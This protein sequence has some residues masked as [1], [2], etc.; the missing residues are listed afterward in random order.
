VSGSQRLQRL[1][2]NP[3]AYPAGRAPG[4]D[5][6]HPASQKCRLSAIPSSANCV[7]LLNG[8]RGTLLNVPTAGIRGLI[9][10]VFIPSNTALTTFSIPTTVDTQITLAA[11]VQVASVGSTQNVLVGSHTSSA[12]RLVFGTGGNLVLSVNGTFIT[13]TGPTLAAG[14]Y[15]VA[16]SYISGIGPANFVWTNLATGQVTTSV[17]AGTTATTASDGNCTVGAYWVAGQG[18]GPVAAASYSATYLS[19]PKLLA[20]AVDP[21]SFWYPRRG[22][23]PDLS[24]ELVK[25]TSVSP[26]VNL[27]AASA[28]GAVEAF[29]PSISKTLVA[30]AATGTAEGLKPTDQR[31]LAAASAVGAVE[32]FKPSISKTLVDAAATG[33][34][35]AFKPALSKTL[36]AASTTATAEA[37]A[38]AISKTLGSAAAAGVAEAFKPAI[39]KV[40]VGV[41]ATA[42]AGSLTRANVVNL[43]AAAATG[44]AG[45]LL[46]EISV[47]LVSVAASGGVGS[48]M[49]P[50]PP[51]AG[52]AKQPI[53]LA[54]GPFSQMGHRR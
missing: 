9:G 19:L 30:A 13:A 28:T 5:P 11:I 36:A 24:L 16:V 43:A 6:T 45:S 41:A 22:P 7:S 29:K 21:W 18:S 23:G 42:A 38:P 10:P 17:V 25:R 46:S 47:R 3:L 44:T 48:F 51:S 12:Y 34:V 14:F 8:F 33:A 1:V 32:A 53:T 40:L 4:F 37:F 20:W 15:F 26:S 31:V 39:S 52:A 35:E 49:V 50:T 27:V 2:F 54:F